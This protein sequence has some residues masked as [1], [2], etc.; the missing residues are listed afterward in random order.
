MVGWKLRAIKR[1]LFADHADSHSA[2][3]DKPSWRFFVARP[4]QHIKGRRL[5]S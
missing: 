1:V 2:G 5:Q 3:R 4:H